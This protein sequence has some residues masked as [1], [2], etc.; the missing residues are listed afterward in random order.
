MKKLFFVRRTLLVCLLLTTLLACKKE[1]E[2]VSPATNDSLTPEQVQQKI[3]KKWMVNSTPASNAKVSDFSVYTWFEFFSAD[4]KYIVVAEDDSYYGTYSINTTGDT[5]TLQG[6]GV[7]AIVR[8]NDTDFAFSLKRD[9]DTYFSTVFTTASTSTVPSSSAT[10]LLCKKMWAVNW[11]VPEGGDT[12]YYDGS[13]D[14]ITKIEVCFSK[15]GT[16]WVHQEGIF[17]TDV[18]KNW[19]W[20]NTEETKIIL[21]AEEDF[22]GNTNSITVNKLTETEWEYQF[23]NTTPLHGYASR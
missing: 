14:L 4:H 8:L 5:L 11:Q 16:Y 13:D 12:I 1:P 7:I 23:D 18:V 19:K 15:N 3:G 21:S 6:F 22:S 9:F 20:N 2:N 10:D 17:V